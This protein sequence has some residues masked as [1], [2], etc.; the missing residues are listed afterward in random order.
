M[1][2][3]PLLSRENSGQA[4]RSFAEQVVPFNF[5]SQWGY[6]SLTNEAVTQE[7]QPG[8]IRKHPSIAE[9]S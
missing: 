1:R 5:A 2:A 7:V 8:T 3:H 9:F 4:A 6:W